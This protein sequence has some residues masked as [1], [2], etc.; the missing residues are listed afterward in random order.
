MRLHSNWPDGRYLTA[1][2]RET[3]LV[4]CRTIG[5]DPEGKK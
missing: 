3:G 4:L 1:R 5:A 2:V